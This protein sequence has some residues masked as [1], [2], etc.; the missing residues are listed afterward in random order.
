M[1]AGAARRLGII[2]NKRD[3]L[4]ALPRRRIYLAAGPGRDV[5]VNL[6]WSPGADAARVVA[7]AAPVYVAAG[8]ADR[9]TAAAGGRRFYPEVDQPA[10]RCTA[11]SRTEMGTTVKRAPRHGPATQWPSSMRKRAP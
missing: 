11:P 9:L 4:K 2:R 1:C 7:E 8:A 3:R 10:A 6:F 5:P